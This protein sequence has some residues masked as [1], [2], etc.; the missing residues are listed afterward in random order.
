MN[1]RSGSVK[2]GL[3]KFTDATKTARPAKRTTRTTRAEFNI[4]EM[5]A[6]RLGEKSVG[7]SNIDWENGSNLEVV[8]WK[9]KKPGHGE[10]IKRNGLITSHEAGS[11]RDAASMTGIFAKDIKAEKQN[12]GEADKPGS[13]WGFIRCVAERK[14]TRSLESVPRTAEKPTT[15]NATKGELA[16]FLGHETFDNT[17]SRSP[18]SS[19]ASDLSS[20]DDDIPLDSTFDNETL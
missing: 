9:A 18:S 20:S 15:D 16:K 6:N 12:A 10:G 4:S 5:T 17:Q 2:P 19:S 7:P 14:N 1:L 11:S 13:E 8:I 3:D